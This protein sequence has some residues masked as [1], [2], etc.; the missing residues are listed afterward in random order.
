[1]LGDFN[2]TEAQFPF[3]FRHFGTFAGPQYL[4]GDYNYDTSSIEG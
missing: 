3:T 2:L 1:M 4:T